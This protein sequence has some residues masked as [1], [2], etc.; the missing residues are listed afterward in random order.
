MTSY[1]SVE[2]KTVLYNWL[3]NPRL[4]DFWQWLV[5]ANNID[6]YFVENFI[7]PERNLEVLDIGAGTSEIAKYLKVCN[8]I[9]IE[10]N[11]RYVSEA[12]EA[13]S[14]G[15]H[16]AIVGDVESVRSLHLK[17]DRILLQKVLHHVDEETA[18]RMLYESSRVLGPDGILL[19]V[20]TCIY[21][22]QNLIAKFWAKMDR[23]GMVR[24]PNEYEDLVRNYFS[25]VQI[26]LKH[27]LLRFPYTI[28]F[29]VARNPK[30]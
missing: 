2:K 14:P 19:T 17:F 4:Y 26:I 30:L 15:V 27:D 16:K 12:L 11:P 21:P 5:G 8:Y 3:R 6:K 28:I 13:N 29:M 25:D 23:G 22:G 20:D 1:G 24:R 9:G 7:K 18:H 10:P